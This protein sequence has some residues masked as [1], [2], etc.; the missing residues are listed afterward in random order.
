MENNSKN[1][2]LNANVQ[3]FPW[4]MNIPLWIFH[5]SWTS[6]DSSLRITAILEYNLILVFVTSL[7]GKFMHS[8]IQ[9]KYGSYDIRWFDDCYGII[10]HE[11]HY[12]HFANQVIL[13]QIGLNN[14]LSEV[15]I[16]RQNYFVIFH[17][18]RL[19][20][21]NG[22]WSNTSIHPWC[23]VPFFQKSRK[24]IKFSFWLQH[25]NSTVQCFINV[26]DSRTSNFLLRCRCDSISIAILQCM[27]YTIELFDFIKFV[28]GQHL[29][30]A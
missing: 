13:L 19:K 10:F 15:A 17:E 18:I 8:N 21:C 11:I 27:W 12:F 26:S 2:Q 4:E 30:I 7:F 24:K 23:I 20:R 5:D 1:L 25:H 16:K 3:I 6:N 28:V 9:L 29:Q 14:F 22:F